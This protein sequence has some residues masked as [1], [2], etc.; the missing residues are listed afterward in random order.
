IDEARAQKLAEAFLATAGA[1]V[2]VPV[3]LHPREDRITVEDEVLSPRVLVGWIGPGEGEVGDAS[4]RVAIEMLEKG[5]VGLLQRALV[6]GGL[7]SLAHAGLEVWPRA[8]VASVELAPNAGH[9]V[10]EVL[11]ALDGEIDRLVSKGPEGNEVAV[12]KFLV[13]ARAQKEVAQ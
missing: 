1:P 5:K 3:P 12:A 6:R 13:H 10:A 7:C 8:A 2:E 9:E 4:L 11:R